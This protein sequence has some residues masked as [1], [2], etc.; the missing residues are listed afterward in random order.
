MSSG[1]MLLVT[2]GLAHISGPKK[3]SKVLKSFQV[4]KRFQGPKKFLSHNMKCYVQNFVQY[5]RYDVKNFVIAENL[6][7]IYAK[8]LRQ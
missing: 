4:L 5:T 6:K 8:E 1:I 7:Y 2:I 3:F